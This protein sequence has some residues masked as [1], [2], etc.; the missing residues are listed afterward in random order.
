MVDLLTVGHGTLSAGELAELLRGAAVELV[1]DVRSAPG[2]RRNPQLA[3][4]EMERWLPAGGVD[5]RWE[6]ALGGR[7][8]A[9]ASSRHV[10]WRHPS[11]RAYADHLETAQARSA[12]GCVLTDAAA[13][14]TA[15]MCSETL[16]WRCHRRLVADAAQLL[17]GAT[18]VHLGHDGRLYPHR[19]TEGVRVEEGLLLYDAGQA[20][21]P[22]DPGAP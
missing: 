21:L 10:V 14:R 12:L 8:K 20:R 6:P 1:V 13:R 16:W 2:S 15:V 19:P 4:A 7:R 9:R 3:R 11:F 18:V 5:Y 17:E 22:G